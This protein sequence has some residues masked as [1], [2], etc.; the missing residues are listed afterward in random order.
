LSYSAPNQAVASRVSA[1]VSGVTPSRDGVRAQQVVEG[2]PVRCVSGDQVR[3][4]Q[5]VELGRQ[6]ALLAALQK[7]VTALQSVA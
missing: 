6:P 2:V 3:L 4:G 7:A 5:P 1:S